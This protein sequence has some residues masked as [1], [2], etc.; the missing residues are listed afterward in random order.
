ML[1]VGT[2][3]YAMDDRGRVPLPPKYRDAFRAGVMLVQGS[4][5]PCLR[6]YTIDQF[7]AESAHYTGLPAMQRKGRDLRRIWFTQAQEVQLD[8]QSRVLVPGP[9]REYAQLQGKVVISGCGDWLEIWSPGLLQAELDRIS[10][11]LEATQESV[12]EWQR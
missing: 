5:D 9:Q 3:E 7:N 8:Q 11:V 2:F 6:V 12:G 1:F 4:P 10:S